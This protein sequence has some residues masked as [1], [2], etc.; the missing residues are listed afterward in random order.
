MQVNKL[1]NSTRKSCNAYG[2]TGKAGF[3]RNKSGFALWDA[4]TKELE[5]Q[6]KKSP[7]ITYKLE[8]MK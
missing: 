4:R 6:N 5:K 2:E 3:K 8:V 7:V 1:M